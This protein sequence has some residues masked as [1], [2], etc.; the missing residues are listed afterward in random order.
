MLAVPAAALMLGAAQAG[1]TV[2]INFAGG[3]YA[4]DYN[5]STTTNVPTQYSCGFPVTTTAF[6]VAPS[7]WLTTG[8]GGSNGFPYSYANSGTIVTNALNVSWTTADCWGTGIDVNSGLT[9]SLGYFV[10]T[11]GNNEVTWGMLDNTGWSISL[12][13]LN[14]TFPNGYVI[15]GIGVA[16]V[17]TSSRMLVTDGSSI[18]DSLAPN[19]I[20]SAN[21]NP[22]GP[23]G[24]I[25]STT[26]TAD[27]ITL[28]N[29]S[30]NDDPTAFSLSGLIMT[31]KP[32]ISHDPTSVSVATGGT[33][34]LSATVAALTNGLAYQWRSN[35]VAI[36]GATSATYTKAG[37]TVAD[38]GSHY[39]VVVTNLYGSATSAVAVVT[40]AAPVPVAWDA[41]TGT[42][43]AQDGSGTWDV[44]TANW[45]N[46]SSDIAWFSYNPA[47][48]G[49]GGSGAYTVNLAS[50]VSAVSLTFN[51]NYTITNA[52]QSITMFGA[53]TT[54]T[55][56]SNATFNVP[57]LGT[58]GLA[59][60]GPGTLT[61]SGNN[62][63]TGDTVVN[64]GSLVML[65]NYGAFNSSPFH[66]AVT[67]NTNAMLIF[68]NNVTGWGGGLTAININ[69]GT[70]WAK[71]GLGAFGVV[72]NLTGG[73]IGGPARLDLGT[74]NG[75]VGAINTVASSTTAMITNSSSVNLRTDSGSGQTDFVITTEAGTTSSGI[76]LFINNGGITG[77]AGQR[78]IK[79]G[80]GT[81]S[82][83]G[84]STYRRGH[85][86]Q[87]RHLCW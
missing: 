38:S 21:A 28:S 20:Y 35:G 41:D 5:T 22:S 43:G 8:A 37:A 42:A 79:A 71:D 33:I 51:A 40:V 30:R 17:K 46:G 83:A 25:T 70:V 29:P 65:Q 54:I 26:Y 47:T 74:Y 49:V 15:Q 59:K 9:N 69:R 10:P 23:V 12:S 1:T 63:Y 86:H 11:P 36:G 72:Y 45:W 24:L 6:G 80:S 31:D 50:S 78:V 57:L 48:I 4:S 68:S 75:I 7:G 2:G 13:G 19:P 39:D 56:N 84:A 82:L 66:G 60:T 87:Q 85:Y 76:D 62:T 27:A 18:N 52:A 73:A 77:G 14:A 81:L 44:T 58:D 3:A 64:A 16:N 32:V 67:V 34:S 61:L 55:A 53:G